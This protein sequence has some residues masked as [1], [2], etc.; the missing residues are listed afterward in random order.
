MP[1]CLSVCFCATAA[2]IP[3]PVSSSAF[4]TAAAILRPVSAPGFS[5]AAV[6]LHPVSASAFPIANII[7]HPVP[8]SAFLTAA[9]IF[10]HILVFIP[11]SR[12]PSFFLKLL[13]RSL[14]RRRL[15]S[16]G[17]FAFC[18]WQLQYE[19][20]CYH[21]LV[22]PD[23]D[24]A[25]VVAALDPDAGQVLQPVFSVPDGPLRLVGPF[26][27]HLTAGAHG[28]HGQPQQISL[29]PHKAIDPHRRLRLTG[30]GHP[31]QNPPHSVSQLHLGKAR[32]LLFFPI[33]VLI[34]ISNKTPVFRHFSSS[35]SYRHTYALFYA[36]LLRKIPS[37]PKR[38]R[39]SAPSPAHTK[40]RPLRKT[41]ERPPLRCFFSK[42]A[43][44][45]CPLY[46]WLP[47]SF[48]QSAPSAHPHG[49]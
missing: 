37:L 20:L 39:H 28:A 29:L 11:L 40:R 30:R 14:F 44:G 38:T 42:P 16:S 9:L 36:R 31:K 6:I 8:A 43:P 41:P 13:F 21:R 34:K 45:C 35:P 15:R 49:R 19:T 18:F 1:P 5:T 10:R 4:P 3:H 46:P 48:F 2:D 26:L 17:F 32:V 12:L 27:H 33:Y 7:L 25:P 24:I 22:I 47:Q 23:C